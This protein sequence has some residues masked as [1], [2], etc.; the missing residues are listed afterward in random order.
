MCGLEVSLKPGIL[1]AEAVKGDQARTRSDA[2]D[3]NEARPVRSERAVA[4]HVVDLAAL[5]G[6]RAGVAEFLL[7]AGG[8]PGAL[9]AEVLVVDDHA[10]T[11]GPDE[12]LIVRIETIG[13]EPDG[14][15]RARQSKRPGRLRARILRVGVDP[16]DRLWVELDLPRRRTRAGERCGPTGARAGRRLLGRRRKMDDLVGHD[17]ANGRVRLERRSLTGRDRRRHCVD[18]VVGVDIPRSRCGE[19]IRDRT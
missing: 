17:L 2:L 10:L 4:L 12:V 8:H 3:A 13:N 1:A 16:L 14:D 7:T 15:T 19:L 11:V 18:H 9:A 6:D 5:R